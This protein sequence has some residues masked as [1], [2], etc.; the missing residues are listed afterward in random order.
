MPHGRHTNWNNAKEVAPKVSG[1]AM[2]RCVY[3]NMHVRYHDIMHPC[4]FKYIYEEYRVYEIIH[5]SIFYANTNAVLSDYQKKECHLRKQSCML[6][7]VN[8][9]T[10]MQ[11]GPRCRFPNRSSQ[12]VSTE[13]H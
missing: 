4:I 10:N 8:S 7:T 9:H 12:H 3:L 6:K 13:R 11:P 1:R 5:L 2:R